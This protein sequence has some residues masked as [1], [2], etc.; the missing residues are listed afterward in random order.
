VFCKELSV[1]YGNLAVVLDEFDS[2]AFE[3]R[4]EYTLFN[5][6][7]RDASHIFF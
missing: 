3:I 4:Q 6:R 7:C 5:E 2:L 1:Q